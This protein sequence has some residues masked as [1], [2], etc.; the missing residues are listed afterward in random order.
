MVD[1]AVVDDVPDAN[2]VH[3]R[4]V[5]HLVAQNELSSVPCVGLRLPR[6]HLQR[7]V[8]LAG[9]PLAVSLRLD[10]VDLRPTRHLGRLRVGRI[11]RDA[12]PT[13]RH[14]SRVEFG[15]RG[16]GRRDACCVDDRGR[17]R[18]G[19]GRRRRSHSGGRL[20]RR[21]PHA[22]YRVLHAEWLQRDRG[23]SGR[24]QRGRRVR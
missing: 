14:C 7:R 21:D 10:V 20:R 4:R 17:V 5:R 1:G 6:M 11:W 12:R 15:A 24:L 3:A 22:G 19:H 2:A 13:P 9:R 8:G 16:E 23:G 18:C